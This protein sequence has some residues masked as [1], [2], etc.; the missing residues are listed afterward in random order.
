MLQSLVTDLDLDAALAEAARVLR[1]GGL[2]GVDL[3]PDLPGWSEYGPRVRMRGRMPDGARVTLVESVRQDRRRGLTVFDEAFVRR[4]GRT[5]E[6]RHFTLTFRTLPLA[7]SVARIERAGFRLEAVLGDYD[8]RPWDVR[9][10]TW[11]VL[12]RRLRVLRSRVHA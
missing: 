12:A 11:I 9:A 10:D 8:G 1:P 3:V 5:T 7:D 6:R 4:R 2:L